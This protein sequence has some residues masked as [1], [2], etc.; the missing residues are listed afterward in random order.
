MT[1]ALAAARAS[2][3]SV[4]AAAA[5]AS[6]GSAALLAKRPSLGVGIVLAALLALAAVRVPARYVVAGVLAYLPLQDLV[7]SHLQGSAQLVARYGP[8]LAVYAAALPLLVTRFDVIRS[9]LGRL[10]VPLAL[11]VVVWL[12]TALA[13]PV[14]LETVA[15]GFRSELRFL[16]LLVIPLASRTL[17]EDARLYARILVVAAAVEALVALVEYAG[18]TAVRRVLAPTYE[19]TLNG[20][21]VGKAGP[22]LDTIFGTFP[23]RNDLGVFLAFG[24][25]VLAAAGAR[26]LGLHRRLAVG[27]GLLLVLG[28]FVSGSREGGIVLLVAAVLI[29]AARTRWPLVRLAALAAVVVV[30]VVALTAPSTA[31]RPYLHPN[32]LV[33]RWT[34]LFTPAAWSPTRDANFRLWYLVSNAKLVAREK[35]VLGYGIGTVTDH[36]TTRDGSSPVWLTAAG[37]EAARYGYQWDGNWAL[38]LLEVGFAGIAALLLLLVALV[39]IGRRSAHWA[40]DALVAVVAGTAILGFFAAT[41]QQRLPSAI[42]WLLVG[43]ALAAPKRRALGE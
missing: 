37:A 14:S 32:A 20:I 29:G 6:A 5:A 33:E 4:V 21:T 42:L 28:T 22:P 36:R 19:I 18:G 11:L 13:N 35:P 12:L 39:Y 31:A 3:V 23:H 40:G 7:L 1:R 30:G 15:I 26:E 8:E 16:P 34:L 9:R 41:L 10:A 43:L 17:V 24:F 27:I 38:L 2:P 25:A